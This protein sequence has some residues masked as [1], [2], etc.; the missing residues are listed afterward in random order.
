M[1]TPRTPFLSFPNGDVRRRKNTR[2]VIR[3]T[4]ALALTVLAAGLPS[5][6]SVIRAAT[7]GLPS[8]TPEEALWYA[9]GDDLTQYAE[10]LRQDKTAGARKANLYQANYITRILKR[11]ET[12][13]RALETATT[14][15]KKLAETTGTAAIMRAA[16]HYITSVPTESAFP[17]AFPRDQRG[18][19]KEID[20]MLHRRSGARAGLLCEEHQDAVSSMVEIWKGAGWAGAVAR[21]IARDVSLGMGKN[22]A[23]G[24]VDEKAKSLLEK[25]LGK[26]CTGAVQTG[27][28]VLCVVAGAPSGMTYSYGDFD[29]REVGVHRTGV[30]GVRCSA[31][32]T[33]EARPGKKP[34]VVYGNVSC[35]GPGA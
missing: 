17:G 28:D 25:A 2:R 14:I 6:E 8:P 15:C 16:S 21:R 35:S 31:F 20:T 5:T 34:A 1:E 19:R 7:D 33:L 11:P 29:R 4:A 23:K 9:V 3:R 27:A 12:R 32:V 13:A 10:S 18:L 22:T 24:I 26:T 30:D